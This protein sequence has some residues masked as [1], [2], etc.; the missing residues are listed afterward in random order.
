MSFKHALKEMSIFYHLSSPTAR[1]MPL[2]ERA[3][4]AGPPN[5]IP[6]NVTG[7]GAGG[8]APNYSTRVYYSRASMVDQSSAG[9][10]HS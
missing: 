7:A 9:I 1:V 10:I 6:G 3:H 5:E 4:H 2:H 8:I